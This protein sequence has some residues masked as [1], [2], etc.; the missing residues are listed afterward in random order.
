[1]KLSL[2]HKYLTVDLSTDDHAK[3]VMGGDEPGDIHYKRTKV[4]LSI[5]GSINPN[6]M[7][8][9]ADVLGPVVARFVNAPPHNQPPRLI[10]CEEELAAD[11]RDLADAAAHDLGMTY[12]EFL[13]MVTNS[14]VNAWDLS[15]PNPEQP[16]TCKQCGKALH[17]DMLGCDVCR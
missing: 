17:P 14:C 13:K 12:G 15:E 2:E 5:V 6:A 3:A 8:D 16:R 1:M 7:G 10:D 4:D 11:L 9:I